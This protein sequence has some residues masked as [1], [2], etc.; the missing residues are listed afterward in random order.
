M[1]QSDQATDH[2]RPQWVLT[3]PA[4]AR[5][6]S[7]TCPASSCWRR[8]STAASSSCS[9][10]S[11]ATVV[12]CGR[13]GGRAQVHDRREHLLR[14][15]PVAGRATVLVWWKRIWRCPQP[16]CP[17]RTW[18]ERSPLGAPRQSL[19][20]RAKAWVTRRVGADGE[21]VTAVARTLGVGWW[22]VMRAVIEVG[23]AAGRRS[24]PPRRRGRPGRGR[25]RLAAGQR[26]CGTPSTPPA[27]SGYSPGRPA[28]LLEVVQGRSGGVYGDWLAARPRR[29]ASRS[30]SPRWTRSAA[31]STRCAPTCPTPR[32]CWTPSTS[33]HWG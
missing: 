4:A 25:A 24:G 31:T 17:V 20:S 23:T 15:V 8:V 29:G 27:W 16:T 12:H 5:K 28:R 33:P 32:T 26:A 6:R 13:C 21:T 22:S 1:I 11:M 19:T 18:T 2:R 3:L 14:D 9:S 30:R 7:L 10:R